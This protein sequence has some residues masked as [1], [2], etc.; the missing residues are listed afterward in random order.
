MALTGTFGGFAVQF[1]DDGDD[2]SAVT[3]GY[4]HKL[5]KNTRIQF[6][7]QDKDSADD[8]KIVARLRVDF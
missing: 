4:T 7:A 3:L 8:A 2:D 5:S 1:S 6:S